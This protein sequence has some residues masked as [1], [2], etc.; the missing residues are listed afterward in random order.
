MNRFSSPAALTGSLLALALLP[1]SWPGGALAQDVEACDNLAT[2]LVLRPKPGVDTDVG[3]IFVCNDGDR[4]FGIIESTFPWC[5]LKT[6]VHAATIPGEPAAADDNIP[7]DQFGAPTP[8]EFADGEVLPDCDGTASFEI[9]LDEIDPELSAGD[10]LA[11]A[12][13]ADVDDGER[14]EGAWSEGAP[15]DPE[16]R[17][18]WAMYFIY[19]LVEPACGGDS[20]LMFVTSQQFSGALGGL[21]GAD[22][23]CQADADA[24]SQ[25]G[26]YRAWL[27]DDT[28]SPLSRFSHATVPYEAVT[29]D[30]VADNFEDLVDGTVEADVITRLDGIN[31]CDPDIEFCSVW[32]AVATATGGYGGGATCERWTEQSATALFSGAVQQADMG[33]WSVVTFDPGCSALHPLICVQQ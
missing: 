23:K 32:S 4:L 6:D 5:L 30:R 16:G 29:G 14:K 33:A 19:T 13:H 22:S 17:R 2:D 15:F 27:A 31:I 10:M 21:A 3:N 20:C 26:T 24:A 7:Q 8:G 28:G 9:F 1:A 12:V 25:S 18:T 11:M